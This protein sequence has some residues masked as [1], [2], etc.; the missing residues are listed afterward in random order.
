[1]AAQGPTP[2][3]EDPAFEPLDLDKN[4]IRLL[5]ILPPSS[6][7]CLLECTLYN[8]PIEDVTG[9]AVLSF[10]EA[11]EP[12]KQPRD[13]IILCNEE[14][15]AVTQDMHQELRHGLLKELAIWLEDLCV[16]RDNW[17][18]HDYHSAL[19]PSILQQ[20][21]LRHL[22]LPS[23]EYPALSEKDDE[24]RLLRFIFDDAKVDTSIRL[25]M[26]TVSLNDKPE[27]EVLEIS[28]P[29]TGVYSTTE[30]TRCNGAALWLPSNVHYFLNAIRKLDDGKLRDYWIR[31]VCVNSHD[32][33][34][35]SYHTILTD[36]IH[37]QAKEGRRVE[38]VAY[39]H[40]PLDTARD[41][42]R[43]IGI[44]PHPP[45]KPDAPLVVEV[46]HAS[47][48]D[49]PEYAALSYHWGPD[50][51]THGVVCTD[52]TVYYV[53][54]NLFRAL[55]DLR[56]HS[57]S[58]VWIDQMCINQDDP[59]ERGKQVSMMSRIYSQ[60]TSVVVELGSH[61]KNPLGHHCSQM[62]YDTMQKLA[63]IHR[64]L[65]VER[66]KRPSLEESELSDY[67]IPRGTDRSWWR[68]CALRTSKWFL[69]AWVIQEVTTCQRV[70]VIYDQ[71]HFDWAD[72]T[73]A[74]QALRG[75][76]SE[77]SEH[78]SG[79]RTLHLIG[80][81][82]EKRGTGVLELIDVLTTLRLL[83]A[84]NPRDKIYAFHGLCSDQALLP[85]PNYQESVVWVYLQYA[86][87]FI[88][89]G[90]GMKLVSESGR[91]RQKI[92]NLPSWVADWSFSGIDQFNYARRCGWACFCSGSIDSSIL[93]PKQ[94]S[95]A[96]SL[97]DDLQE[98]VVQS[99]I[100]DTVVAT[101]PGFQ[102]IHTNNSFE[103]S[104][105]PLDDA[106]RELVNIL[107]LANERENVIG[108]YGKGLWEAYARTLMAG[109]AHSVEGCTF[110]NPL[111]VYEKH[112]LLARKV[113]KG[114]GKARDSGE[115]SCLAHCAEFTKDVEQISYESEVTVHLEGHRFCVT[116]DGYLGLVPTL[117]KVGDRIC[118]FP[119]VCA[120]FV[121]T[122]IKDSPQVKYELVGD[123]YIH[124]LVWTKGIFVRDDDWETLILH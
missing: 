78:F 112:R 98:L 21:V 87:F 36:R 18:E 122:E 107:D 109:G 59:V 114:K 20:A 52:Q 60:A 66:P 76:R 10:E 104:F 37:K 85:A 30:V 94:R 90:Q 31:D 39:Q 3:A 32:P 19:K 25:R 73:D 54:F 83:E 29:L 123:A 61:C 11:E 13:H 88:S 81:I 56:L 120:P 115:D 16:D 48:D 79:R 63:A 111:L 68:W 103:D 38:R 43:L 28:D 49:K 105:L 80:D 17:G 62:W 27:Y 124:E 89:R 33:S 93:A 96:V 24:I 113:V 51:R 121:L 84:T 118:V 117:T 74:N 108:V 95:A 100:L 102:L 42:I 35:L 99:A 92:P 65:L 97:T 2:L 64:R 82:L 23:F 40:N 4:E 77:R 41:A 44:H 14:P 67:E 50:E 69:R 34:D 86:R 47:L 15:V 91:S 55:F 119:G 6:N 106:A 12:W 72:L 45:N 116:A 57:Y 1:M 75:E 5:S 70:R 71:R 101:T 53:T 8:V 58:I 46:F 110:D 26:W 9:F 22:H 7:Y